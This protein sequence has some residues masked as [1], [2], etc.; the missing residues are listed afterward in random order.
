MISEPHYATFHNY[1]QTETTKYLVRNWVVLRWGTKFE[2]TEEESNFITL[3]RRN[4]LLLLFKPKPDQIIQHD[5]YQIPTLISGNT[6]TVGA[7]D[8]EDQIVPIQTFIEDP[9]E[10][11]PGLASALAIRGLSHRTSILRKNLSYF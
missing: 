5:F 3:Y 6:V 4:R 9:T 7:G 1:L 10:L 2:L 11:L 8:R